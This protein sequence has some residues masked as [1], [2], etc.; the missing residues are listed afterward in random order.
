MRSLTYFDTDSTMLFLAAK[1]NVPVGQNTIEINNGLN[2]AVFD[3]ETFPFQ[4]GNKFKINI[5]I[6]SSFWIVSLTM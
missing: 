5:E 3:N 2:S 4:L 1:S 6:G